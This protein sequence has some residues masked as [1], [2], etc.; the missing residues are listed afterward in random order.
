MPLSS[1]SKLVSWLT[2]RIEALHDLSQFFLSLILSPSPPIVIARVRAIANHMPCV[3]VQN[4]IY[5]SNYLTIGR[6]GYIDMHF[7]I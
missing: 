2:S 3:V 5:V 7:T 6:I 4:H 1:C